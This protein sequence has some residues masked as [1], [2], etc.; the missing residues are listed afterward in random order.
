MDKEKDQ[1]RALKEKWARVRKKEDA[2]RVIGKANT[3]RCE[4]MARDR[5]A[6]RIA[7]MP[8]EGLRRLSVKRA[9]SQNNRCA[10]IQVPGV[11]AAADVYRLISAASGACT[12]CASSLES[13]FH[14]DHITPI[15]VGGH[16]E[17][18]NIRVV[19]PPCNLRRSRK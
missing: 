15:C 18:V 19:C 6:A 1:R 11:L 13:G 14:L 5:E 4:Q 9:A 16:N 12:V 7:S 3:L 8:D 2:L 17:I 10:S